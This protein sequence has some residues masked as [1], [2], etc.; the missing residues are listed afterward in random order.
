M[1]IKR[2][3]SLTILIVVAAAFVDT[4]HAVDKN[5]A[6]WV[7]ETLWGVS[8]ESLGKRQG[9][10]PYDYMYRERYSQQLRLVEGA[11][12]TPNVEYLIKGEKNAHPDG[13]LDYTLRAW[14]NH[15]RALNSAITLR[16]R[17]DKIYFQNTHRSPAECYLQRALRFSPKDAVSYMLYGILLQR[18]SYYD[19]AYEK[20][21]R[22]E[23][24]Q[25]ENLNIKYNLGL[26]LV[27]MGRMKEAKHYAEQ[28]Y[29]RKFPLPGLQRRL[30]LAK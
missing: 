19:E 13:D 29:A 15:H 3:Q 10:G 5:A 16:L 8:C 23:D 30:E 24:L 11:H 9:Y 14:P 27:D 18:L 28:V 4:S 22:A 21:R 7:G 2:Y 20:Y 12:F 6:P 17:K 1:N 25:P 26:L